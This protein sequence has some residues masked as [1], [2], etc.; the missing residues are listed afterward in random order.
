MDVQ[1]DSI[2]ARKHSGVSLDDAWQLDPEDSDGPAPWEVREAFRRMETQ[3]RG[4]EVIDFPGWAL[5]QVGEKRRRVLKM[6]FQGAELGEICAELDLGHDNAYAQRPAWYEG[7]QQAQGAL[8]H[9]STSER[10]LSDFIDA[11]NAGRRP[12]VGDYLQRVPGDQRDELAEQIT[13]WLELVPPPAY[14]EQARGA[15]RSEPIVQGVLSTVGDDVGAWPA[16][17]PRLRR[18]GLGR[19]R[20]GYDALRRYTELTPHNA[21]AWCWLGRACAVMGTTRRR[22]RPSSGQCSASRRARSRPTPPSCSAGWG[23]TP[24]HFLPTSTRARPRDPT[25]SKRSKV[26]RFRRVNRGPLGGVVAAIPPPAGTRL[27]RAHNR[28]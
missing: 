2:W 26:G 24:S 20:E 27:R 1:S 15:I 11:W 25:L 10:V 3:G 21:W 12:R 14:S 4:R 13:T 18:A 28:R 8:R 17:L 23:V 16:L 19:A 5:P 7:P 22:G 9:M 6:T